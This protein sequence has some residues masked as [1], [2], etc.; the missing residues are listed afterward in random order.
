M[1]F[2]NSNFKNAMGTVK[3]QYFVETK[4]TCFPCLVGKKIVTNVP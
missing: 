1:E 3:T 4:D 2:Q